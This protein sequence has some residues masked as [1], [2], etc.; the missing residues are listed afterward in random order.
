M[1]LYCEE[2]YNINF[3]EA[4]GFDLRG[5]C[6]GPAPQVVERCVDKENALKWLERASGGAETPF[7][8]I[9]PHILSTQYPVNYCP[10]VGIVRT[11][12]ETQKQ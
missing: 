2:R 6:A 4:A 7:A 3:A 1:R 9:G 12:G 8:R 5:R 10:P 11:R